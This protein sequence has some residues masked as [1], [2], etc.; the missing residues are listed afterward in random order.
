MDLKIVVGN[1]ATFFT[2]GVFLAGIEICRKIWLKKST[3]DI[4]ALPFLC[5]LVS[6]SFWLRYGLLR[7]DSALILVNFVGGCLQILYIVWYAK[8]TLSKARFTKQL[9]ATL[10][11]IGILYSYTTYFASPEEAEYFAGIAACGAGVVFMASPLAAVAHVLRTKNVDTLPFMMIMCTFIMAT[12][13]FLYG[14]LVEDKFVQVP[15]F[16]GAVLALAQLSLFAM[17]PNKKM[18][19]ELGNVA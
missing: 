12:L 1:I 2:I 9:L 14:V 17:Y 5:G 10:F 16:L 19:L 8:F 4:S 11:V 3:N 6:C 15:N 13:W 7:G 18:Y